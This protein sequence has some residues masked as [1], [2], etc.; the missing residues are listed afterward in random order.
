MRQGDDIILIC[1]KWALRKRH[2][3]AAL[4]WFYTRRWLVDLTA[5]LVVHP[6]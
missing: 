3:L 2:Y 6:R 5:R 4:P 1:K